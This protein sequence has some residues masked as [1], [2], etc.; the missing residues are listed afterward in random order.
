[1]QT[2]VFDFYTVKYLPTEVQFL[3]RHRNRRY[4]VGTFS[5]RKEKWTSL[6]TTLLSVAKNRMKKHVDAVERQRDSGDATSAV[7]GMTFGQALKIYKER[8]READ[9]RPNTKAYREAGVKLVLR[10][11]EGIESL[12]VRRLTS[13][14]VESWLRN[15]KATARPHVPIRAK[16]AARNSTG[17]SITTLKC[18]LDGTASPKE[19]LRA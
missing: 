12:N 14:M 7:G 19:A 10:S 6:R 3:Y 1:M 18:A 17:A 5:G 2:G 11:W 4:Y 13:P 15:L 9:V 8:L 16:K